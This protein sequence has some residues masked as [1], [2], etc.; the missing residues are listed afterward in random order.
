MTQVWAAGANA[1]IS[2][3]QLADAGVR[4]SLQAFSDHRVIKDGQLMTTVWAAGSLGDTYV[5]CLDQARYYDHLCSFLDPGKELTMHDGRFRFFLDSGAYSAWSKGAQIDIDEYAEF[6]KANIEHLD[7]YVNL[8]HISGKPGQPSTPQQKEEGA[9][10]SWENFLYLTEA[11]GIPGVVPVF[12]YGE[13]VKWLRQMLDYGCTY[14][15]LGGMVGTTKQGRQEWL[16]RIWSEHLVD[17]QGMPTVKVH[18]FGMTAVDH[19]FRYPWHSVDSTSWL[20]ATAA[21]SILVPRQRDGDFVFD[22]PPL[23]IAVSDASPAAQ[24]FGRH[25][26]SLPAAQKAVVEQWVAKCGRTLQECSAHYSHR[27]VVNAIFFRSVSDHRKTAPFT[28]PTTKRQQLW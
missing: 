24:Q 9:R 18:G 27:A 10:K 13:D 22:E 8:D 14:I 23:T 20:R 19:I 15:G 21:G 25:S 11:H 28:A 2:L 6:I 3:R 17:A 5:Q 12:H 16:D 26:H 1:R 7:V 4:H